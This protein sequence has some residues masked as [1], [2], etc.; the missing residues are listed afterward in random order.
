METN[1]TV[2]GTGLGMNIVKGLIEMMGGEI[3]VESK[4]GKGTAFTVRLPQGNIGPAVCG[5]ELADNLRDFRFH[6]SPNS[7]K[8][9]IVYEYM[10]Y[11]SVLV[12]DDVALNL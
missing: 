7:K 8:T 9:Q 5:A 11:G 4:A 3:S 1:R 10:P 6:S 12:V 2:T